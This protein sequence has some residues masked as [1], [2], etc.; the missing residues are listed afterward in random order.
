MSVPTS[1]HFFFYVFILNLLSNFTYLNYDSSLFAVCCMFFLSAFIAYVE[2]AISLLLPIPALR[3]IYTFVFIVLHNILVICEY[4]LLT[5]FQKVL[6]QDVVD[7]LAETNTVEIEN[8]LETYIS[9][10]I[11]ILYATILLLLNLSIY[12]LTKLA[13]HYQAQKPAFVSAILGLG[14]LCLCSYNFFMYG[15]GMSIPQ[16]TTLT[17]SGYAL[18]VMKSRIDQ[19]RQLQ[20]VCE[21]LE[22]QQTIDRKPTV[23]VIIGESFSV[24]HSSLYG[25]KKQT[26]PLL[27]K[28]I[29]G[30]SL[31]LFDNVV[32]LYDGTHGSMR[33]VFSLDSLGVDFSSKALFPACFKAVDYQTAMYDNQYFVGSGITFLTDKK[34]SETLFDY[35]NEKRYQYDDLMVDDIKLLDNP[36]FYV[37]HLWGQHY[38]YAQ[39]FPENFKIFNADEYDNKYSKQ[40]RQ[41]MADYDNATLYNDYVVEK[42]LKK[43]KDQYCC[44]FYFSDHGEEVYELRDY[45]GHGNAAHSPNLNYQLRVPL[46]IWM[47]PSFYAKNSELVKILK[48]SE[49][50]PICTDDI[51]HPILE[52][53]GITTKDFAP[54]RSFINRDFYKKRHR[55]VL[56]SIDY[57][58]D[59][60]NKRNLP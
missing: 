30:G 47:S 4:F 8:F 3:Y 57:D 6:N 22:A 41:M 28:Y 52:V 31:F 16:Y 25:Y 24:Y 56:E 35:R 46:M 13:V 1:G 38:T 48:E 17:R 37:I 15:N 14:V 5:N 60:V 39:R 54:T 29:S 40:C 49:H 23:V 59:W 27:E 44:V 51:G 12:F 20:R 55:I 32:S 34:L 58:N 10:S 2:S 45:M 33:A 21:N 36:A 26:N 9:P 42:I 50:Y 7:I 43:F 18:Y 53:A 11:I 19:I